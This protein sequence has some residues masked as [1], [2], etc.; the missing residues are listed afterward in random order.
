M[1]LF[2][3]VAAMRESSTYQYIL[4]EGRAQEARRMLLRLGC[5]R[6]GEPEPAVLTVIESTTDLDRLERLGD[7][8]VT[9]SSWS[10]LLAEV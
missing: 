6:F 4:D 3:G 10:E 7:R 1:Q 8:L 5:I 9:V 2:A